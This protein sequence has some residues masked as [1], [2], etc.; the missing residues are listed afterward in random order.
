V[1]CTRTPSRIYPPSI[2]ASAAGAKAI[3]MYDTNRNGK[4]SGN[5]MDKCPGLKAAVSRVD[6]P[7]DGTITASKIAARIKAWQESRLG[8]MSLMCIVL[9]NGSPLVGAEVKCVPERFL[10]D[11]IKTGVGKTDQNG[12]AVISVPTTG[13]NDRPGIGPGFY[14]VEITKAG[15]TVPAKYNVNTNLGVEVAQDAMENLGGVR[16]NLQY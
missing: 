14:R 13:Q 11:N 12:T 3:E 10:G 1:G 15:E 5:E 16:F 6:I 9:R 2:D 4:I 7:K 8:R